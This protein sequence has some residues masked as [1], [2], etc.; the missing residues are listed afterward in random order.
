M[1]LSRRRR[2][3]KSGAAQV[4]RTTLE[5]NTAGVYLDGERRSLAVFGPGGY[6]WRPRLDQEVLVLT[7]ERVGDPHCIAGV[8]CAGTDLAPGEVRIAAQDGGTAIFLRNDGS[9]E[10][11]GRVVVNGTPIE[12]LCGKTEG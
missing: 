3:E 12:T 5:G 2:E 7:G 10:L 1:W 4:G 6:Q 11:L 8:R 9:L